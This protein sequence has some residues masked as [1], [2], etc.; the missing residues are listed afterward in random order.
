M[1]NDKTQL[2]FKIQ[3]YSLVLAQTQYVKENLKI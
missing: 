1:F 2:Q 3:I